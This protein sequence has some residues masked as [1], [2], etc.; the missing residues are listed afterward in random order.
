MAR[1]WIE[2][3]DPGTPRIADLHVSLSPSGTVL[4]SRN[5]YQALGEPSHI[6]MLWEPETRTIGLRPVPPHT[7]N[8]FKLY[9]SGRAGAFRFHALRFITKHKIDLEYTARF[10]TA[11]MENGVL[12]LELDHHVRSPRAARPLPERTGW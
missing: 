5:A 1:N 12:T 2:F 7:L 11:A 9:D 8:A 3:E 4:V 10:P 6:V